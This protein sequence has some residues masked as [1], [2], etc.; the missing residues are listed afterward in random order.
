M[1]LFVLCRN[2]DGELS[3]QK[4]QAFAIGAFAEIRKIQRAEDL[5]AFA[6]RN[7]STILQLRSMGKGMER[8]AM[9]VCVVMIGRASTLSA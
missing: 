9:A 8:L 5:Y 7:R 2:A 1:R 4:P 6:R 3:F